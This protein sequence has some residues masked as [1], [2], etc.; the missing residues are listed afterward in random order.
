MLEPGAK[1]IIVVGYTS[2][3][4]KPEGHSKGSENDIE[5]QQ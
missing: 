3:P 1:I 5:V 2:G 4:F